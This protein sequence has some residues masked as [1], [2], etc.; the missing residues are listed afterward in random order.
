LTL[1]EYRATWIIGDL[2]V[3]LLSMGAPIKNQQKSTADFTHS[4]GKENQM[5][6]AD[7][8]HRSF[9]TYKDFFYKEERAEDPETIRTAAQQGKAWGRM[10]FLEKLAN[11]LNRV[12]VP[13]KRGR[14][15]KENK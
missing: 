12:V 9:F 13:Q 8:L 15:K 10:A 14:P 11:S 1:Q 3:T 7:C 2:L 4:L 5:I 6:M